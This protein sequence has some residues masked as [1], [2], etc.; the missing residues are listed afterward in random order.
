MLDLNA[1]TEAAKTMIIA[2]IGGGRDGA[3]VMLGMGLFVGLLWLL[4]GRYLRSIWLGLLALELVNEWIDSGFP[5]TTTAA[6]IKDI[7]T[8]M[9]GPTLVWLVLAVER[10]NNARPASGEDGEQALE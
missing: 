7:V 4:R 10:R 1:L 2:L 8:T 3:H 5:A 9:L 6:S